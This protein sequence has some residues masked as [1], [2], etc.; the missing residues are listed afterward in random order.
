MTERINSIE[1]LL[2]YNE[3]GKLLGVSSR[4]VWNFVDRGELLAVRF[5][6]SVRIDPV[7][8]RAFIDRSKHGPIRSATKEEGAR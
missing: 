2:T 3:A 7:D 6:N 5:G 8:L 1:E 4:T